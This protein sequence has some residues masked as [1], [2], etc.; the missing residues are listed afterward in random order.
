MCQEKPFLKPFCVYVETILE[1]TML[2]SENGLH[3]YKTPI[4]EH[5]LICQF[6]HS[7]SFKTH[8][9]IWLYT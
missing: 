5:T 2:V 6:F 7:S 3:F 1:T 9:V 8:L 4:V